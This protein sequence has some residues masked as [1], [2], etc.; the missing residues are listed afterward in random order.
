MSYV[1]HD[2]VRGEIEEYAGDGEFVVGVC[3]EG[4]GAGFVG[5]GAG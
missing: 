5:V 2:S 1:Q 4:Y 3:A